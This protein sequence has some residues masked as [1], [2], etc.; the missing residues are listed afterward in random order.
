MLITNIAWVKG[1]GGGWNSYKGMIDVRVLNEN[2]PP[3]I[4]NYPQVVFVSGRAVHNVM[5]GFLCSRF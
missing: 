3:V 5:L 1:G 4:N 2:F